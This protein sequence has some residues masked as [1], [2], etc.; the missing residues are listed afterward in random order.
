MKKDAILIN[1]KEINS[2]TACHSY[3]PYSISNLWDT[4]IYAKI[5]AQKNRFGRRNLN[6]EFPFLPLSASLIL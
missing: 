1:T 5:A 6:K 3:S 4:R 2:I